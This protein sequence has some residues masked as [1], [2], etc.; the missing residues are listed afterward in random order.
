MQNFFFQ[1]KN[2]AGPVRWKCGPND[3][4]GVG[5][6]RVILWPLFCRV[7]MGGAFVYNLRTVVVFG[8]VFVRWKVS[9]YDIEGHGGASCGYRNPSTVGAMP[10][11]VVW[12]SCV[13]R[14]GFP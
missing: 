9:G 14:R 1:K 11:I 8:L 13:F 12:V 2:R 7:I 10:I 5:F 3:G 4:M 6:G